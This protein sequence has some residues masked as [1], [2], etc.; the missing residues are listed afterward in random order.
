MFVLC[1]YVCVYFFSECFVG[2]SFFFKLLSVLAIFRCFSFF[3][4]FRFRFLLVSLLFVRVLLLSRG[5]GQ[6]A[7]VKGD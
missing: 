4:F 3:F 7:A 6:E 2:F 5:F 1:V